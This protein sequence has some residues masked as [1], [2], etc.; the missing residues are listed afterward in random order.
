MVTFLKKLNEKD[1]DQMGPV[2]LRSHPYASQRI[3]MMEKELPA[4][5]LKVDSAKNNQLLQS[6]NIENNFQKMQVATN[7]VNSKDS[8]LPSRVMCQKCRR[9]FPGTVKYCPYDGTTLSP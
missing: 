8:A 1:K 5:I 4:I 6:S 9:I 7:P 2:F 3:Q